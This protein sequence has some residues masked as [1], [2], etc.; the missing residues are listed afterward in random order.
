[1]LISLQPGCG[2]LKWVKPENEVVDKR[3]FWVGW[4]KRRKHFEW[5]LQFYPFCHS[6]FTGANDKKQI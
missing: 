1:M 4:I 6:P 5:Q 2:Q 3:V